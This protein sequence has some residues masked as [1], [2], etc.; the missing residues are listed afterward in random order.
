MSDK[1][2]LIIRLPDRITKSGNKFKYGRFEC[3]YCGKEF[4]TYISAIK[5]NNRYTKSCG[6]YQKI[7]VSEVKT[8]HGLNRTKTHLIWKS[9]KGR[10]FNKNEFGYKWYG[11]RGITM[12]KEW[13][14]NFKA[15][16]NYVVNLPKYNE[17]NL[18]NKSGG[19]T[20]DRINN[21]GNYEPGNLRWATM[22]EQ[23][24]NR[25]KRKK[26]SDYAAR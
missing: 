12:Y 11:A 20:I 5:R 21:D 8:T 16:H 19:L 23:C 9:I 13:V 24:N 15:F 26:S 2:K 3:P 10:C 22:K 18:T 14:K 17:S 4:E 1:P 6:C 25:R 7:R